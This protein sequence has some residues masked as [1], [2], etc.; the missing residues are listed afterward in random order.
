MNN[1]KILAILTMTILTVAGCVQMP[2][3]RQAV[4]DMRP[5]ISFIAEPQVGEA[6]IYIDNVPVGKVREFLDGRAALRV[7][8]GS[9]DIRVVHGSQTLL[10]ERFYIGDGVSKSFVVR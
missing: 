7:V 1:L 3:E 9:H 6:L 8:P 10:Q 2:T 5:Q 4:V